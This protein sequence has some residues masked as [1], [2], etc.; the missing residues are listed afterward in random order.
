MGIK[1]VSYEMEWLNVKLYIG[2]N[3]IGRNSTLHRKRKYISH[4]YSVVKSIKYTSSIVLVD[5]LV[6]TVASI[7]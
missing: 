1:F 2:N 4:V 5:M 3:N 6:L 7:C